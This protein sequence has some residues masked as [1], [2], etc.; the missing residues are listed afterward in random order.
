MP[1]FR[2]LIVEDEVVLTTLLAEALQRAD[3]DGRIEVTVAH[4]IANAKLALM[5]AGYYDCIVLGGEIEKGDDSVPLVSL[6]RDNGFVGPIIAYSGGIGTQDALMR[7]GATYDCPKPTSPHSIIV[8][9]AY[10]KEFVLCVGLPQEE[11]DVIR[12]SVL[13]LAPKLPLEWVVQTTAPDAYMF[14]KERGRP[15]SVLLIAYNAPGFQ[16]D[17]C[18]LVRELKAAD[19]G[20]R[21]LAFGPSVKSVRDLVYSGCSHFTDE[22]PLNEKI[23][24]ILRGPSPVV[25]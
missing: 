18:A 13:E 10:P 24:E 3:T 16:P 20:E 25:S 14:L 9:H 23:V 12:R 2:V 1:N 4:T 19:Y 7:A 17:A 21:M 8:A 11:V 22:T 15:M 6:A 5:M